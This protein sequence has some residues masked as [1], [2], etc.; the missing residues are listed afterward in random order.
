MKQIQFRKYCIVFLVLALLICILPVVVFAETWYSM[1]QYINDHY[2]QWKYTVTVLSISK[3]ASEDIALPKVYDNRTSEE[4]HPSHNYDLNY[5]SDWGGSIGGSI[6]G[7]V[8]VEVKR[9]LGHGSSDSI[10]APVTV[11]PHTQV[12]VRDKKT[13]AYVIYSLETILQNSPYT[14]PDNWV[15]VGEPTIEQKVGSIQFQEITTCEEPLEHE[16]DKQAR[17]RNLNTGIY[18]HDQCTL[19]GCPYENGLI[20]IEYE[21]HTCIHEGTS[22]TKS[23]SDCPICGKYGTPLGHKYDYNNPIVISD[24]AVHFPCK[25]DGCNGFEIHH[26]TFKDDFSSP[27]PTDEYLIVTYDKEVHKR[28]YMQNRRC[29]Y[30][31]CDEQRK[32]PIYKPEPHTTWTTLDSKAETCFEDGYIIQTC[33]ACSIEIETTIPAHGR[34]KYDYENPKSVAYNVV[35]YQCKTPG[36]GS[37]EAH[38]HKYVDTITGNGTPTDSYQQITD[39]YTKHKRLYKVPQECTGENHCNAPTRDRDNWVECNHNWKSFEKKDATCWQNGYEKFRCEGQ[40]K[41]E[42]TVTLNA[43]GKHDYDYTK[44]EAKAYN[45]VIYHC[46][47]S[48]CGSYEAHEHKYVDTVTGNGTPTDFYQQITDN[49]TKHKRLYKVPQ[50]CTGTNHCNAPTRDRDNW[51]EC[52]HNWK[53]FDKK[54]ATCWQNGYIV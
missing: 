22:C 10:S 41:M 48:G 8:D 12:I 34:H 2:E 14:D 4:I 49:Y 28:L 51:V 47:T 33:D 38:E 43:T 9:S 26:H 36:C 53:S 45:V 24:D 21:K 19:P 50:E 15:D 37:Y 6:K 32:F 7:K 16:I 5:S 40:C 44:P 54:A 3:G 1:P 39:N 29:T 25:R 30:R 23:G 46:K 27:E 17:V 52:N 42:K 31:F 11:K 18:T 35:I 13:V 20:P